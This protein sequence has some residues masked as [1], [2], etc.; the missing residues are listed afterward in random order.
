MKGSSNRWSWYFSWSFI[1]TPMM[2]ESFCASRMPAM[3]GMYR[4]FSRASWTRRTVSGETFPVL[5]WITL[6]TVAVLSPNSSAMSLIRTRSIV[7][8]LSHSIRI[9]AGFG[10]LA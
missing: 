3:L 1:T 9:I 4:R 10:W 2:R 6:E 8:R 7:H 5:P